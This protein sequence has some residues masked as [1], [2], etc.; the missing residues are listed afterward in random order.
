MFKVHEFAKTK[1]IIENHLR[2][3]SLYSLRTVIL[4]LK[5]KFTHYWF[6]LFLLLT[7]NK[8]Y[9]CS[10]IDCSY[11]SSIS[12]VFL[13]QGDEMLFLLFVLNNSF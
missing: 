12:A 7:L 10:S 13:Q 3:K 6:L 11:S 4:I 1:Q 9:F 2:V 5:K 8:F